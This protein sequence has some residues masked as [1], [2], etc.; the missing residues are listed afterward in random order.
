MYSDSLDKILTTYAAAMTR[1]AFVYKGRRYEPKPLRVSPLI[2]RHYTCPPGCGGCCLRFS[3]VYLPSELLPDSGT[4]EAR[5]VEFDGRHVLVVEDAQPQGDHF[6]GQLNRQTGRCGIHGR[7][8]FSCDFELIRV[9]QGPTRNILIQKLYGRGS[10][11]LRIDGK[12]GARCE[13][14]YQTAAQR[15]DLARRLRRLGDWLDHFGLTDTYLPAVLAY[16]ESGP[17]ARPLDLTP[18]GATTDVSDPEALR[19]SRRAPAR[20]PA[21]GAQVRRP[22][23]PFLHGG[24]DV[25]RPEA[26]R[27][28]LRG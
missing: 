23:R 2:F 13:M 9:L 20:R 19:V 14:T 6:C 3:L 11:F 10:Q 17:H 5:T 18:E 16:V 25:L 24:G 4:F 8:P 21:R 7:H 27:R 15:A 26:G 22:A 28:W 12:R 1:R